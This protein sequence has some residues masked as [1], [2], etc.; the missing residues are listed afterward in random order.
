MKKNDCSKS[1]EQ[2]Y[3]PQSLDRALI[4]LEAAC[5]S[6]GASFNLESGLVK[7]SVENER[8]RLAAEVDLNKLS[9]PHALSRIDSIVESL[10]ST[11]R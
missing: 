11:F 3:L 6:C 9:E 10:R 7:V 4:V 8:M 5:K 1:S 2:D